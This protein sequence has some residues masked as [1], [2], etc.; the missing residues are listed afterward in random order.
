MLRV[1]VVLALDLDDDVVALREASIA[2]GLEAVAAG[3][4]R[5]CGVEGG[6]LAA[7]V[8]CGTNERLHRLHGGR[9]GGSGRR[10]GFG[11]EAA[12]GAV[13]GYLYAGAPGGCDRGTGK[14]AALGSYMSAGETWIGVG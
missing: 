6:A 1:L 14:V 12:H 5:I 4:T 7:L 9:D 3:S 8:A 2:A 13:V 11:W 10:G